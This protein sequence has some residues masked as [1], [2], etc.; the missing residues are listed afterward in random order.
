MEKKTTTVSVRFDDD[1]VDKMEA[2]KESHDMSKTEV[3][4]TAIDLLYN[5]K[6]WSPENRVKVPLSKDTMRRAR[7]LHY[8]F[9]YK[10]NFEQLISEAVD[11]GMNIL[12]KEYSQGGG[13]DEEAY[14]FF[15]KKEAMGLELESL[16]R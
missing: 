14:D 15:K 9:G 11:R 12:M 2:M 5:T 6:G 10:L 13:L 7:T 3:I 8:K 16:E 1:R 4:Q